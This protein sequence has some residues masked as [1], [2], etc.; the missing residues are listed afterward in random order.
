[1]SIDLRISRSPTHTRSPNA[2]TSKAWIRR[3]S[4]PMVNSHDNS[5]GAPTAA[6]TSPNRVRNYANRVLPTCIANSAYLH[7]RQ[8]GGRPTRPSGHPRR[9]V[10]TA[11]SVNC[12]LPES[13]WTPPCAD[14]SSNSTRTARIIYGCDCYLGRIDHLRPTSVCCTNLEAALTPVTPSG[15]GH[16]VLCGIRQIPQLH[17]SRARENAVVALIAN[18][19]ETVC[20]P[21][22]STSTATHTVLPQSRT[23]T[24][25]R[26]ATIRS[27]FVNRH[28]GPTNILEHR[29]S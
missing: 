22:A 27:W 11:H 24:P 15:L 3:C 26:S 19:K 10:A 23:S 2:T 25:R 6:A 29:T 7:R 18:A 28:R 1:M 17:L 16:G 5:V 13:R 9:S 8:C 21:S 4:P 12:R 14:A 20:G